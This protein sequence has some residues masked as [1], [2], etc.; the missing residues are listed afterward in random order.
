ML[1]LVLGAGETTP[2][3][4][5]PMHRAALFAPAINKDG[6]LPGVVMR[7][8]QVQSSYFF[9]VKLIFYF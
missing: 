9:N 6:L 5:Q 4:D 8:K 3:G 2:T 7:F 1:N